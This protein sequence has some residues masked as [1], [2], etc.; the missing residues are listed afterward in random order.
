MAWLQVHQELGRHPKT[1]RLAKALNVS[2]PTALGHLLLLWWWALDYAQDGD[3]SKF[4]DEEIT[5][6]TGW[7]EADASALVNALCCSG[8]IDDLG[9]GKY[10]IHDWD[11][12][13]GSLMERRDT[14]REQARIRQQRRRE[15]VKASL[16]A[17]VTRDVTLDVTHCHDPRVEKSR[18]ENS[19]EEKKE[20]DPHAD[21]PR[22]FTAP[23][24]AEIAA[25][26][27]ERKNN[28]N[29][30]R[31]FDF[32]E[33]K[34]WRVGNQPMKNWKAAVRTWEQSD[35]QSKGGVNGSNRHDYSE[36]PD[37]YAGI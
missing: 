6:A 29:A 5:E 14:Q 2:I 33:S 8:F 32:Y 9:S 10:A 36:I 18:V 26:C 7:Q 22:R 12:Y 21:K 37:G 15:A 28:I 23:S 30:Q 17:P 3:L 31:F 19:R 24:V 1:K 4:S 13:A 11:N 16:I 35:E 34:G 27:V 20:K 25:Y